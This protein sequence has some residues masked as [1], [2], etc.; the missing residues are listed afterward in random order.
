MGRRESGCEPCHGVGTVFDDEN[1][2]GRIGVDERHR[3]VDK[4]HALS[5]RLAH[6]KFVG[7]H[8]EAD[9]AA[10]AREQRRIVDGFGQKIVGTRLETGDAVAGLV[11]SSDHHDGNMGGLGIGLDAA[12][13]FETVHAGH[14]YVQQHDIGDGL[15]HPGQAFQ[16][17][18]RSDDF[19]IFRR[20]LRFQKLYVGQDIVDDKNPGRHGVLPTRRSDARYPESWSP[21]SA[22]RYKPRI[23]P[24]G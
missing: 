5:G 2:S 20:Q 22:W 12:A 16:A 3:R 9:K 23:R 15:F 21:K 1:A 17:V 7:H 19:E 11:Q 24:G 8:L 13:D 4:S 6:A 18:K 10:H 14:H